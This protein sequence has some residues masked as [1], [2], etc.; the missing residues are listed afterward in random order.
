MKGLAMLHRWVLGLLMLACFPIGLS[1]QDND[2]QPSISLY[3]SAWGITL[4]AD[5]SGFYNDLARLLLD[6]DLGD[7][8]YMIV[9]YR[10]ATTRFLNSHDSC[11]YPDSIQVLMADGHVTSPEGLVET[12]PVV[13]AQVHIFSAPGT[14]PPANL[15]DMAGKSI[16]Y[17]L[18]STTSQKLKGVELQETAVADEL[19]KARMLLTGRVDLITASLPDLKF[20]LRKL[21][22]AMLPY[23]KEFI[24]E[25]LPLGIV[26]KATPV[27]TAFIGKL[28]ARIKTL[29]DDETLA[30]FYSQQGLHRRGYASSPVK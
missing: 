5:G 11:R 8:D 30:R 16:A 21:G 14:Q 28:D 12:R 15:Q 13:N 10:R 7:V 1:A 26:C 2:R 6:A 24:V 20:V 25:D 18:G 22:H 29:Q 4:E 27:T 23:S 17:Q 19:S 3:A 9:P